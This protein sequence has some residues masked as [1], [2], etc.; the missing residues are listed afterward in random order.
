MA[1]V[2]LPEARWL[3]GQTIQNDGGGLFAYMG[4]FGQAWAM[5]PDDMAMPDVSDAPMLGG[6]SA[7]NAPA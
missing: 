2:C 3:N 5:V 7:R 1:L 6:G 4:R